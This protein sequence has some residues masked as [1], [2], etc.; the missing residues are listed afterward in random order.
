MNNNSD[1]SI[2][3]LKGIVEGVQKGTYNRSGPTGT[4]EECI[5][6]ASRPGRRFNIE[7]FS[8]ELGSR[9]GDAVDQ[10]LI[11]DLI[12]GYDHDGT[13][14]LNWHAPLPGIDRTYGPNILNGVRETMD[15]LLLKM[16]EILSIDC[17]P[18]NPFHLRGYI[19]SLNADYRYRRLPGSGIMAAV[20]PPINI[21]N[22]ELGEEVMVSD[23]FRENINQ[24]MRD[25]YGT[26]PIDEVYPDLRLM[27]SVTLL[28][29]KGRVTLETP[30][31][32]PVI[33]DIT[34]QTIRQELLDMRSTYIES[35]LPGLIHAFYKE[36]LSGYS[37]R[38]GA[39][40]IPANT[41]VPIFEEEVY[42]YAVNGGILQDKTL[43]DG[44]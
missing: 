35:D 26:K 31:I 12:N 39:N 7:D 24:W 11:K 22:M 13:P 18:I 19:R 15:D 44:T 33:T 25:F 23:S 34:Y 40:V 6:A 3:P 38:G 30:T 10:R 4:D 17:P 42:R 9:V 16:Q 2:S 20:L 5:A 43:R 8:A 41:S 36:Q 1:F 27:A 37:A 28:Y 32:V 21:S 14:E 29:C